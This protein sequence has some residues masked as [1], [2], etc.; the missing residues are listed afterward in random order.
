MPLLAITLSDL[1]VLIGGGVSA[2]VTIGGV[3]YGLVRFMLRGI[4][5]IAQEEIA[6][7]HELLTTAVQQNGDMLRHIEHLDL[8]LSTNEKE[9]ERLKGWTQGFSAANNGA[10]KETT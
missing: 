7:Q 9:V 6:P 3:S 8:R 1:F 10:R 5:T 4:R 2:A